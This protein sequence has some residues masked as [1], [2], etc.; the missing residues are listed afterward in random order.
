MNRPKERKQDSELSAIS[1]KLSLLTVA[2]I[3]G[4]VAT[5]LLITETPLRSA[6]AKR[7]RRVC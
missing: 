2:L 3:G 5:S 4:V 7:C 1:A 6:P